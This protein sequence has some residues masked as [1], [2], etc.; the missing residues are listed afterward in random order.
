MTVDEL[1]CCSSGFAISGF[2]TQYLF[3]LCERG[4]L[5]HLSEFQGENIKEVCRAFVFSLRGSKELHK[6]LLPRI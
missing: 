2:G 1:T 5:S 6:I 4:I 3:D